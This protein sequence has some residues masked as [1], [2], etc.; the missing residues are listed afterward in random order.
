MRRLSGFERVFAG[1]NYVALFG[2]AFFCLYPFWDTLVLSFMTPENASQFGFRFWPSPINLQAYKDILRDDLI[3]IGY[4]NTIFRTAMGTFVTVLATYCAAYA[5][6]KRDLLFRGAFT[7]FFVLTLFFNGGLIPTYLT[8][9]HLGLMGSRWALILPLAAN[10]WYLVVTRSFVSNIPDELEEA[11][12]IDGAH[13]IRIVFSIMLPLSLPILAVI[14]LWSAVE[15]WNDWFH[16]MLYV[17]ERGKM[18]LQLILR[19][20]LIDNAQALMERGMLDQ[21][22]SD[23]TPETIKAAT[24]VVTTLPIIMVYPF[25]QRFFVKGIMIGSL[26]G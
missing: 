12:V 13:P 14:S 7:T 25:L 15:H 11:A 4:L 20:L 5:L 17:R 8:I 16:A 10:A 2:L 22:Y 26:K 24:I 6:S 21:T 3:G 23:T 18:V 1:V 19:R 9:K